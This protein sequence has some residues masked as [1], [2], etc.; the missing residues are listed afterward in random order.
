MR[1]AGGAAPEFDLTVSPGGQQAGVRTKCEGIDHVPVCGTGF[2]RQVGQACEQVSG[3]K[4]V[5]K[6]LIAAA[7]GCELC[8]RRQGGG[9]NRL[10]RLGQRLPEHGGGGADFA[11]GTLIDPE[12][13]QG[14]LLRGQVGGIDLVPFWRHDGFALVP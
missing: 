10:E 6:D 2:V 3:G 11:L 1:G 14:Q 7:R 9:K 4:V 13:E 8:V 12:P 5:E